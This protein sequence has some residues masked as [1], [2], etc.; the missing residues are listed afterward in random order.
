MENVIKNDFTVKSKLNGKNKELLQKIKKSNSIAIHI[1]RGDYVTNS[2]VNKV[3]GTCGIDYYNN[4]V[5]LMIRKINDPV[6]FIF[7]DDIK[8]TKDN[9]KTDFPTIYVS[10]NGPNKG[11][12]D[13]RLMTQCKHFIIANS[14]FCWWGAWLSRNK[15]KIVIAPKRWF[16]VEGKNSSDIVPE[17]WI[18]I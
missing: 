11:Y 13:M 17:K 8:W 12:E 7:S 18:K 6:F 15:K 10:H 3:H 14:S 1:R 4:A 9:I 16:K 2:I 5:N